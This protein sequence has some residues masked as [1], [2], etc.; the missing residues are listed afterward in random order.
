MIARFAACALFVSISLPAAAQA[1]P[2]QFDLGIDISNVVPTA[3]AVRDFL[4]TLSPDSRDAIIRQ[5]QAFLA[6]PGTA[7]AMETL[8]F[9]SI[10]V[11]PPA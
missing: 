8:I 9:C 4:S 7:K 10:A 6:N 3:A 11:S 1:P 2:L 5:C